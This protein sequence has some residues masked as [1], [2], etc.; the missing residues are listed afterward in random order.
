MTLAQKAAQRLLLQVDLPQADY[1]AVTNPA[2]PVKDLLRI[3]DEHFGGN[4]SQIRIDNAPFFEDDAGVDGQD[5][6]HEPD[7]D[8]SEE[9]PAP[10][11]ENSL[12]PTLN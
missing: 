6:G 5:E 2:T 10:I 3:H 4:F 8:S 1:E 7:G 9:Q 11:T 12:T